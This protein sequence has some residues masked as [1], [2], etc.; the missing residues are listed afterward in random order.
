MQPSQCETYTHGVVGGIFPDPADPTSSL[1]I[2]SPN[3][4]S[5]PN[6]LVHT[7]RVIR[8]LADGKWGID[9]A[10][11]H[12]QVFRNTNG[13]LPLMFAPQVGSPGSKQVI[14]HAELRPQDWIPTYLNSSFGIINGRLVST[15]EEESRAVIK[16]FEDILRA[17]ELA[18]TDAVA[19]LSTRKPMLRM[20]KNA[21]NRL[22]IPGAWSD[23][24]WL[25]SSVQRLLLDLLAFIDWHETFRRLYVD[26]PDPPLPV[27]TSRLGAITSSHETAEILF[28]AGLPTYF[29]RR[30]GEVNVNTDI[31]RLLPNDVMRAVLSSTVITAP[32]EQVGTPGIPIILKPSRAANSPIIF[33]GDAKSPH[34]L[35]AMNAWLRRDHP[36]QHPQIEWLPVQI[37][38]LKEFGIY[39]A[40]QHL[41]PS[42]AST[43]TPMVASTAS[44]S[45]TRTSS[46]ISA[47]SGSYSHKP[48]KSSNQST[49]AASSKWVNRSKYITA[50]LEQWIDAAAAAGRGHN[51]SLQPTWPGAKDSKADWRGYAFPDAA[52]V[53]NMTNDRVR[54]GALCAY[55]HYRP[56]LIY[57][58]QTAAAD[59]ALKNTVWRSNLVACTVKA[60][61][62]G[63]AN[64]NARRKAEDELNR[65]V[66]DAG[67]EG[68]ISLSEL[69]TGL[70]WQGIC[71]D[72]TKP[73]SVS[74]TRSILAD[75][76]EVE[77][78]W[79]L[80][81]LDS[82]LYDPATSSSS[83]VTGSMT[84]EL[85]DP[86]SSSAR[87]SQ[88]ERRLE[89]LQSVA[90][91]D[92]RYVPHDSFYKR[93]HG[94]AARRNSD[95]VKALLQLGLLMDQWRDK[96]RLSTD[97][98]QQVKG[99]AL[100]REDELNVD[101]MIGAVSQAE[102][103]IARH[104]VNAFKEV[105]SRA[106][107]LPRETNV[108]AILV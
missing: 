88:E 25:W 32:G 103:G 42:Q 24:V 21:L 91:F 37:G 15:L 80:T 44:A 43:S 102:R 85:V 97:V 75:M 5:V 83:T 60:S 18:N 92:G 16:K 3:M 62:E 28:R 84:P 107:T 8:V 33:R 65:S 98:L 108:G 14:R 9:D 99:L 27:D 39:D 81:N 93:S 4:M 54:D 17:A 10:T 82:K 101:G 34:R 47:A 40:S 71:I 87:Y 29:I 41:L 78:R 66:K 53:A 94:F 100:M 64:A 95:K 31:K 49:Q 72:T 59:C 36:L 89:V 86:L 35:S 55:V 12:P 73:L 105:F 11:L 67:Y 61:A 6:P 30:L 79:E 23:C 46:T 70:L 63:S 19:S 22:G 2:S 90:H 50:P 69:P 77:W 52:M 68:T 56:V 13:H 26:S 7:Q 58:I 38:Q 74:I 96:W 1:I 76:N 51:D 104:Y 57:R 45:H 106:P 20:F 48:K